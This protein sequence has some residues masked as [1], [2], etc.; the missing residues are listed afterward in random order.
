[1]TMV[2]FEHVA[3][4][5]WAGWGGGCGRNRRIRKTNP[6][7]LWHEKALKGNEQNKVVNT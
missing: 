1:M 6:I 2:D 5:F 4:W 3:K 7:H